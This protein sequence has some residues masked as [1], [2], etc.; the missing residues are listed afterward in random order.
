MDD[1]HYNNHIIVK[2]LM[3]RKVARFHFETKFSRGSC[4]ATQIFFIRPTKNNDNIVTHLAQIRVHQPMLPVADS[5]RQSQPIYHNNQR[6]RIRCLLL[7]QRPRY[8]ALCPA[9]LVADRCLPP[10]AVLLNCCFCCCGCRRPVAA[11]GVGGLTSSAL[12]F[13]SVSAASTVVQSLAV[14]D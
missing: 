11:A 2:R 13:I 3:R 12:A 4:D 14:V 6:P 10:H 8:R 9:V 7:W 1:Q 5:V